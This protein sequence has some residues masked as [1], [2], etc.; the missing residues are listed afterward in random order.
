MALEKG[1]ISAVAVAEQAEGIAHGVLHAMP[2]YSITGL[3]GLFN[4]LNRVHELPV[5]QKI[6]TTVPR[7]PPSPVRISHLSVHGKHNP[8]STRNGS[9]VTL[10]LRQA[11]LKRIKS[12]RVRASLPS[13]FYDTRVSGGR[14]APIVFLLRV[15]LQSAC[16]RA[17]I[18]SLLSHQQPTRAT[19]GQSPSS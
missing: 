8:G 9:H 5:S 4:G 7:L 12:L 2:S 14:S 11:P 18:P 10:P 6:S 19:V 15:D 13:I 17:A 1:S 3:K 16:D